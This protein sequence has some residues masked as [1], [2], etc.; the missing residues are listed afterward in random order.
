M[1]EVG[2]V[3]PPCWKSIARTSTCLF[4]LSEFI[5][6]TL[7]QRT[8]PASRLAFLFSCCQT[9][10]RGLTTRAL[11]TP[12]S[13]S[14]RQSRDVADLS[15]QC[16]FFVRNYVFDRYFARPT[17][18][19]GMQST[20]NWSRR[21]RI[22]PMWPWQVEEILYSCHIYIIQHSLSRRK[23]GDIKTATKI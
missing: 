15:S 2:G 10:R 20:H 23:A 7:S 18:I 9:E 12:L 19:L 13:L 5:V 3:E 22:T 17:I 21:I 14:V 6:P 4:H 11:L 8:G 16:V 1:V